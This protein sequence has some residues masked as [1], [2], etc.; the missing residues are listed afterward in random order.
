[1]RIFNMRDCSNPDAIYVGRPSPYGNLFEIGPDGD[2]DAV[3]DKFESWLMLPEQAKLRQQIRQ[4]LKG[5]DLICW[6]SPKRCHAESLRKV[7]LSDS[8]DQL[9]R[10]VSLDGLI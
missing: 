7:A 2:R 1:M 10:R 5:Y 8:D 4:D 6:C 3:C 9:F